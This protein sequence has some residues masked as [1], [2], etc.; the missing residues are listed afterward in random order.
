MWLDRLEEHKFYGHIDKVYM[1]GSTLYGILMLDVLPHSG[2]G[3]L[4]TGRV[5]KMSRGTR[6]RK[7]PVSEETRSTDGSGTES[8]TSGGTSNGYGRRRKE[9]AERMAIAAYSDMVRKV[10][11]TVHDLCIAWAEQTTED[12]PRELPFVYSQN[13]HLAGRWVKRTDRVKLPDGTIENQTREVWEPAKPSKRK[14]NWFH[15]TYDVG[16]TL[17]AMFNGTKAAQ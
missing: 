3:I 1:H 13:Q 15:I 2:L 17:N 14:D 11:T 6:T 4:H 7:T 8:S 5:G 9:H 12:S 16:Q 10:A